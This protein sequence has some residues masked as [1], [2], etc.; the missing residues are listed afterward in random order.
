MGPGMATDLSQA[1]GV[2][3]TTVYEAFFTFSL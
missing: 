2:T 3:G 1:A